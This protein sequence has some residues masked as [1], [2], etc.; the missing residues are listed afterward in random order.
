M[1]QRR[2]ADLR[3]IVLPKRP[4]EGH[5]NVWR[6]WVKDFSAQAFDLT[7]I[8]L[9]G[10]PTQLVDVFFHCIADKDDRIDLVHSRLFKGICEHASDLRCA[11]GTRKRCAW[12]YEGPR[13]HR[14]TLRQ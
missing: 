14:A 5:E 1:G 10:K 3:G 8:G 12:P 6:K 13:Q 9:A 7:F 4:A 11:T 2:P